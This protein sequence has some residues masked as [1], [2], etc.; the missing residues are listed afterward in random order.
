MLGTCMCSSQ[1]CLQFRVEDES[2]VDD[3][4][5]LEKRFPEYNRLRVKEAERSAST[6]HDHFTRFT[7]TRTLYMNVSC[8]TKFL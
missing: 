8:V 6:L 4:K 7:C 2:L 1:F 3:L 5:K